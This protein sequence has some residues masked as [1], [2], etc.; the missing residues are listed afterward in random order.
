MIR[1]RSALH[2]G[3]SVWACERMSLMTVEPTVRSHI[4]VRSRPAPPVAG[5]VKTRTFFADEPIAFATP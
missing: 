3:G 2:V 1:E 5:N 4:A